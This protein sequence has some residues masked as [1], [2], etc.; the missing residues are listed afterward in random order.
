[1]MVKILILLTFSFKLYNSLFPQLL[2]IFS[3]MVKRLAAEQSLVGKKDYWPHPYKVAF[4]MI[5]NYI[6]M[7]LPNAVM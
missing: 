6:E 2:C 7:A 3:R 5:V 4:S 1:M